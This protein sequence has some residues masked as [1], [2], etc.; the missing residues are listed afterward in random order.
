MARPQNRIPTYLHHKASG[1]AF[2]RICG[3]DIYLGR[4]NSKAKSLFTPKRTAGVT[5]NQVFVGRVSLRHLT[6]IEEKR[7]IVSG[8]RRNRPRRTAVSMFR[9]C[10][11]TVAISSVVSSLG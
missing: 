3:R 4:H 11:L 5:M 7:L 1:Q 6:S 2:V 9:T 8:Q 10:V